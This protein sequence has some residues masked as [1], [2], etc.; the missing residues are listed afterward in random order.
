MEDHTTYYIDLISRYFSGE[1]RPEEVEMLSVW[2]KESEE[3]RKLFT[4]YK[5]AWEFTEM[6]SLEKKVDLDSE[7]SSLSSKL[8][9]PSAGPKV[10][11]LNAAYS[12][13][14]KRNTSWWKVAAAILVIVTTAAIGYY[15]LGKPENVVVLADAGTL[16]TTLPDGSV[17]TLNKGARLEYAS[18][19]KGRREVS[20]S[21]EAF[22]EV[23]HDA[24]KPFIVSGKEARVEVLG[25][26]FN[27]STDLPGG[28]VAV[29]LASGKVSFYYAGNSDEKVILAPGEQA[30]LS[31]TDHRIQKSIATDPNYLAWKTQRIVFDN[32]PLSRIIT[33][34][35]S[36]YHVRVKLADPQL[37]N[38]R[39][40]ATFDHQP[41]NSVMNV[42][43]IT[44]DIQVRENDGQYLISGR[45]CR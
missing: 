45:P 5:K 36:V 6:S 7:W 42:L 41:L 20:L 11:P 17:V 28:D 1:A 4:D 29:V 37:G 3:N 12:A 22:F 14:P 35:E 43:R 19:F 10:I 32:A 25:T 8:S 33:T 39:V 2:V 9:F 27:V 24:S 40:T 23:A 15:M 18:E 34:L 21:G 13:A 26:K 44:L 38:C 16:S 30:V 31:S